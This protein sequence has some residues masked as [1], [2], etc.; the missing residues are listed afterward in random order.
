MTQKTPLSINVHS[1]E[2]MWI[3][4]DNGAGKSTLL[5][6]IA[7]VLPIE[8]GHLEASAPF[9]YLGAELGIKRHATL[10]DYQRFTKALGVSCESPLSQN[11]ELDSFSS[12]QRLWIRLQ[13]A[14]RSDRP[15]WLLDEPSR[16]LDT[17]HEA[18]LWDKI[19]LHC[20]SGGAAV[21]ASH[22]PATPWISGCWV[23]HL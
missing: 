17:K 20:A 13:S 16:F 22:T 12:G 21:I 23:M 14:L 8:V 2:C 1:G 15:L 4:G 3:K 6:L 10:K 7:G 19:K 9:S 11:R 5:K 18:L